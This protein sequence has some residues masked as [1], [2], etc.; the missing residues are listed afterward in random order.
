MGVPSVPHLMRQENVVVTESN[1]NLTDIINIL[2][3]ETSLAENHRYVNEEVLLEDGTR[4]LRNDEFGC[5]LGWQKVPL[6]EIEAR[7]FLLFAKQDLEEAS[8]RGRVNALTNAKRAIECRIDECLKLLNYK[9][10]SSRP[11]W[12]LPNNLPYKMQILQPFSILAPG[13]LKDQITA[14][15]NLLEHEYIRPRNQQEVRNIVDIAELFLEATDKYVE[16]GYISSSVI[17]CAAWFEIDANMYSVLTGTKAK[18][19]CT[20]RHGT[21]DEYKL[22]FDLKDE[23]LT[24]T[25][26]QAELVCEYGYGSLKQRTLGQQR[27]KSV[28]TLAIPDCRWEDVRELM[29]LLRAK[30]Q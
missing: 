12:K 3:R 28:S 14:R 4:V 19:G 18:K 9:I 6:Y 24:L 8:E 17:T 25:H 11:D 30:G 26:L 2:E 23:T 16:K 15:R 7:E 5:S 21:S 1:I 29:I 22:A 10:F 20:Y 27:E 13:V